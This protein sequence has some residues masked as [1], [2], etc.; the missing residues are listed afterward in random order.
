MVP[1]VPQRPAKMEEEK[2]DQVVEPTKETER[3]GEAAT[4][5]R[6]GTTNGDREAKG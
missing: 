4:K 1:K 5:A 6:K 2:V 3:T